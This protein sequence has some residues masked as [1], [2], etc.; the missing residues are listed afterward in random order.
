MDSV[1]SDNRPKSS[2]DTAEDE[3]SGRHQ[4]PEVNQEDQQATSPLVVTDGRKL[5]DRH[6]GE[7]DLPCANRSAGRAV[8]S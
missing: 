5:F 7:E 8:R 6:V 1:S 4:P 3:R 2:R